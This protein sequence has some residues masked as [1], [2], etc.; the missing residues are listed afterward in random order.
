MPP[1][2]ALCPSASK[3]G[4]NASTL[5]A[6]M[7]GQTAGN[8]NSAI[9]NAHSVQAQLLAQ[10]A[11]V[12]RRVPLSRSK[13]A[14]SVPPPYA[15]H[16]VMSCRPCVPRLSRRCAA[17]TPRTNPAAARAGG[18]ADDEDVDQAVEV[19]ATDVEEDGEEA[20][21]EPVGG[22]EGDEGDAD[23]VDEG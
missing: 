3:F 17:S 23:G 19:E 6:F 2:A 11:S 21:V 15:C 14:A 16:P 12:M 1:G 4:P 10:C 20:L 9:N 7:R 22:D 18:R 13:G 8:L 5:L